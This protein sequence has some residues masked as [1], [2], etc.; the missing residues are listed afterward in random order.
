VQTGSL[1]IILAHDAAWLPTVRTLFRE[2][3]TSLEF[4]LCFQNFE[5]ELSTLPADYAPPQGRLLL[6]FWQ[7]DAAG[8]VA[9]RPLGL[10]VCE[11]KRLFVRPAYRGKHI[12]RELALR[13][14]AEAKAQGYRKMHLDTAPS[15]QVAIALY[16]SLQFRP[17]PPYCYNPLPGAVYLEKILSENGT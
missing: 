14:I 11:M 15:M 7:E 1:S 8:C 13:A 10:E 16:Q 17:I 9:V 2:Y 5:Q 3:A 4:S 6:G 12:G